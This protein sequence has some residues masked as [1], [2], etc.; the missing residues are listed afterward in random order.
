MSHFC[1]CLD[2][3]D[4][5]QGPYLRLGKK[6][7]VK[8]EVTH[9]YEADARKVLADSIEA[10]VFKLTLIPGHQKYHCGWPVRVGACG[11]QM[12]TRILALITLTMDPV[13]LQTN[14]AIFLIWNAQLEKIYSTHIGSLICAVSAIM[15]GSPSRSYFS[16]L[17]SRWE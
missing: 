6:L 1:F 10:T 7:W 4:N 8:W 16:E 15:W 2:G 13:D 5:F 9:S 14:L 12:I 11:G 17:S 3:S